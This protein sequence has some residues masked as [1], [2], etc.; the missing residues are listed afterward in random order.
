MRDRVKGGRVGEKRSS[1]LVTSIELQFRHKLLFNQYTLSNSGS[2]KLCDRL[3]LNI[4]TKRENFGENALEVSQFRLAARRGDLALAT[5]TAA[6]RV[7]L[8]LGSWK[9]FGLDP[10]K[11]RPISNLRSIDR[12]ESSS[13]RSRN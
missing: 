6:D 12:P 7:F 5:V 1:R 2:D 4:L 8:E 10:N 13:S 11:V 3:A 9:Q